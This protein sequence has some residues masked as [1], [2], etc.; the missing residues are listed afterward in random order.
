VV[1]DIFVSLLESDLPVSTPKQQLNVAPR[2]I[3][4]TVGFKNTREETVR[5][6][7]EGGFSQINVPYRRRIQHLRHKEN[8]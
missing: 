8:W 2:P 3:S 4:G 7:Y 5:K 1:A 6:L